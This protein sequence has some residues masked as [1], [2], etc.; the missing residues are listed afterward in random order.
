MLKEKK[1]S[2]N[3]FPAFMSCR[4]SGTGMLLLATAHVEG[5][6][7][8]RHAKQTKAR[9]AGSNDQMPTSQFFQTPV[10][11]DARTRCDRGRQKTMISFKDG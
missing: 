4:D 9:C 11:P 2:L 8:T 6:V 7:G 10:D 5:A 1:I 3:T